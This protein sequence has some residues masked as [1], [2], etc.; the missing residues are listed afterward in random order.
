MRI[1]IAAAMAA[2]SQTELMLCSANFRTYAT[3]LA[4]E[5]VELARAYDY[6][7]IV[8]DPRLCDMAGNK[9]LREIRD[10]GIKTP[11]L[12]L[13]EA[14]DIESKVR[15][16]A[17]GADDYLTRPFHKDE[18]VARLHALIRRS[19]G[20]T[21]AVIKAGLLEINPALHTAE[22]DGRQLR[23]TAKE[24][25]VLEVLALRKGATLTKEEILNH[26]Y[27]G[28]DEPEIKIVDVFVC[29]V[30]KKLE[31]EVEGAS[32]YI[33]TVWGR[34]YT[35]VDEPAKPILVGEV[36]YLTTA[37]PELFERILRSVEYQDRMFITIHRAVHAD[38][39]VTR[40]AIARLKDQGLVV[41]IAWR[42]RAVYRIADAGLRWLRERQPLAE[43]A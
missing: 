14:S 4:E 26:L 17:A 15:A 10:A 19:R 38:E 32:G 28:R 12:I 35:L 13:A 42:G 39:H 30:R 23:L 36:E 2:A 16:F 43:A 5:A 6:D 20:H 1:L 22:I 18:L 33:Q 37:V 3:D 24:F 34:G 8:L 27:S 40:N 29:K 11:I 9:P 41:N 7:A 31:A 21:R 25:E